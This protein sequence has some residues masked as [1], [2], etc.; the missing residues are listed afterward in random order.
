MNNELLLYSILMLLGVFISSLAQVLL[1]KTAEEKQ[2][3]IIKEYINIKVFFAY[4]VFFAAT[5]MAIYGYRVVPLSLGTILDAT[6]YI[7]VTVFGVIIF[8]ERVGILKILA[9]MLIIIGILIYST[10]G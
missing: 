9:L 10:I 8:K 6:G 7:F 5:L 1:K 4:I 3:S 2:D